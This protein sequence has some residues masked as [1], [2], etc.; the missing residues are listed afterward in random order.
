VTGT[1]AGLRLPPTLRDMLVCPLCKGELDLTVGLIR[2]RTGHLRIPQTRADCVDIL[3]LEPAPADPGRWS[4][5]QISM[6]QWYQDLLR[7]P[8][9]AAA[10][11]EKDGP[12]ATLLRTLGGRVLDVGGGNGVVRHYL[13]DGV[14]CV[15]LE[16]ELAWLDARWTD[17]VDRCPCLATP[18]C[19]AGL[20][21]TCPSP[22]S[23]STRCSPSGASTTPRARPR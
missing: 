11:F 14:D 19:F 21:S 2:C 15:L 5:R 10:C 8:A 17:L 12:Y 13:R 1:G 20:A 3:P 18:A 7:T 4:E 23:R 22:M 6:A 9:D 16:P